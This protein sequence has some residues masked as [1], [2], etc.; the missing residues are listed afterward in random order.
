M[1]NIYTLARFTGQPFP[2]A[3]HKDD[4]ASKYTTNLGLVKETQKFLSACPWKKKAN[5]NRI[6]LMKEIEERHHAKYS[7]ENKGNTPKQESQKLMNISLTSRSRLAADVRRDRRGWLK[8]DFS[9]EKEV[10]VDFE[11]RRAYLFIQVC[12][13]I[14]IVSV[15]WG[16]DARPAL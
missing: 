4:D 5:R 6:P 11:K 9:E 14:L 8:Q 7:T 13:I 15:W 1:E 12:G 2:N 10:C 16:R 3:C